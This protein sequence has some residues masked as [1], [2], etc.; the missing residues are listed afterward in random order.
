M[1]RPSFDASLSGRSKCSPSVLLQLPLLCLARTV[2]HSLP[3]LSLVSLYLF[4]L[5]SYLFESSLQ[6][7]ILSVLPSSLLPPRVASYS[8]LVPQVSNLRFL[9]LYLLFSSPK[10]TSLIILHLSLSPNPYGSSL[11]LSPFYTLSPSPATTLYSLNAY[12]LISL[13]SFLL[14]NISSCFFTGL[15]FFIF[16]FSNSFVRSSSLLVK[17]FLSL[18]LPSLTLA[19]ILHQRQSLPPSRPPLSRQK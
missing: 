3:F 8:H 1:G 16:S 10:L 12:T 5:I 6:C 13:I 17:R 7:S 2:P 4:F 11:F 18:F 15:H 9:Y 14:L 19:A